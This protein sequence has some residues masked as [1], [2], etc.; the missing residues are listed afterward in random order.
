M[1]GRLAE[2]IPITCTTTIAQLASTLSQTNKKSKSILSACNMS[3]RVHPNKACPFLIAPTS[4]LLFSPLLD[5]CS[6]I[7]VFTDQHLRMVGSGSHQ[8]LLFLSLC[9][10][11]FQFQLRAS[12]FVCLLC[13]H[14]FPFEFLSPVHLYLGRKK[15]SG[16]LNQ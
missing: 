15:S 16:E 7:A 2:A 10:L 5:Q 8:E 14:H 13:L 1:R 4:R 6:V 9:S 11:G 3:P 12:A